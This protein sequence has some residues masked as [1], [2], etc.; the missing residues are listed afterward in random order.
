MYVRGVAD[1]ASLA[2]VDLC[3]E[4]G[5]HRGQS[6]IKEAASHSV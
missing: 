6:E 4:Y 1:A 2:H 5:R 3:M